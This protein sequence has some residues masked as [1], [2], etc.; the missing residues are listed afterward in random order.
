VNVEIWSDV[1]CP[2]CYVGKRRFEKA[3]AGFER[4]DEVTVTWRSFELDPQAP[5]ENG[6]DVAAL[7][8]KKYGRTREEVVAMHA[9]MTRMAAAE[10]IE[11]RFDLA[12]RG[13]TFDAH[14]LLHLAA[15]H[16]E[17]DAMKERL[18]RA[19]HSEGVAIGDPAA[20]EP[21]AVEVGLPAGE[22]ADVLGGDRYADAVRADERTAADLDIHA[23][24]CFVVDR[25][26]GVAGAQSP[27]LF[28]KLLERAQPAAR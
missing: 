2:W 13:N 8:A 19:Y 3:L 24:P 12:R 21:L 22:V 16:G 5:V 4:R 26:V 18:L 28:R 25:Q 14:R 6:V 27:E 15:E 17:Q 9:D 7:V 10:G 1:A 20:L 11:F 23:V